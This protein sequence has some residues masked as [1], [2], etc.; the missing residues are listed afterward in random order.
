MTDQS[1]RVHERF[2]VELDVTVLHGD[3][4]LAGKTIN[5]SMGGMFI[6]FE[7]SLP[8]GTVVKVRVTLPA[9]K[10]ESDLPATVRWVTPEGIGVQFGPLRAKETWAMNELIKG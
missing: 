10:E 8:F 4:E 6:G 9:L 7:E 2:E 1:R 3:K 5:V